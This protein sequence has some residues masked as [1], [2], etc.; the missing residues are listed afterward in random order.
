M[1]PGLPNSRGIL[2][3]LL[4]PVPNHLLSYHFVCCAE[5]VSTSSNCWGT[6]QS[7]VFSTLEWVIQVQRW[8][9]RESSWNVLQPQVESGFSTITGIWDPMDVAKNV[10]QRLGDQDSSLRWDLIW[11]SQLIGLKKRI[12]IG[13]SSSWDSKVDISVRR[14]ESSTVTTMRGWERRISCSVWREPTN[15]R[16]RSRKWWQWLI[17][18]RVILGWDGMTVTTVKEDLSSHTMETSVV[19]LILF[20][21]I[22]TEKTRGKERKWGG[23]DVMKDKEVQIEDVKVQ[24]TLGWTSYNYCCESIPP[25]I[26]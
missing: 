12:R 25:K 2:T 1:A 26:S 11:P 19:C 20:L 6:T 9:Q 4:T 16:L 8:S 17:T 3:T 13:T 10:W 22:V 15:I 14:T 18:W 23:V 21:F 7:W 5:K 24:H